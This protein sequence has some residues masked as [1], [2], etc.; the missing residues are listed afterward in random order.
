MKAPNLGAF[1]RRKS[2]LKHPTW[3][4]WSAFSWKL[5]YRWVGNGVTNR[6]RESPIFLSL[7]RTSTYDFG[8]SI[9]P[10]SLH[11]E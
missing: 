1:P 7:A 11:I 10:G 5:I 2:S 3:T 9:P 6:K 8:K 4:K